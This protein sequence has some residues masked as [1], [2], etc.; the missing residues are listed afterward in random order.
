MTPLRH[1]TSMRQ[2]LRFMIL[3]AAA[4]FLSM[5]GT[6]SCQPSAYPTKPVRVLIP[7]AAGSAVDVVARIVTNGM[8]AELGQ[9]FVVENLPGAAGL[10]GAERGAKA[11]PDGYT[12]LAVND[13]IMAVLPH[14]HAKAPYDP[15]RDFAPITQLAAVTWLLVAHPSLPASSLQEFLALARARPG[16]LHFASGGNGSPQHLGMELFRSMTRIDLLHVPFKGATPAM[17]D[18]VAGHV[19]VMFTA[20]SVGI[21]FVRE[22][23]VRA[24]GTGNPKR[25]A[26]LPDVPTIAEAGLAGFDYVTWAGLIAPAATPGAVISRL[27]V[28][29]VRALQRPEL[30]AKIVDLGFEISGSTPE[31]FGQTLKRDFTRMGSLIREAGIKLD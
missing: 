4:S 29:A 14:L 19:P 13:S 30:R 31:E 2:R 8:A 9:S 24:L 10:I 20:T 5:P 6:A 17:N 12:V 15:F 28:A 26:V 27:N 3:A 23:R 22:G 11:A 25:L 18:V 7:L 16:K 1:A 21:A